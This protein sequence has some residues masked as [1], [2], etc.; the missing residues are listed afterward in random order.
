MV[1]K[2]SSILVAQ[3]KEDA[4]PVLREAFAEEKVK[5]VV[6]RD[7]GKVLGALEEGPAHVVIVDSS[8]EPEALELL[9]AVQERWPGMPLVLLMD[10]LSA[11]SMATAISLGA[12][13]L[14]V[15]PIGPKQL[16][17][18]VRKALTATRLS[19]AGPPPAAHRRGHHFWS[20]RDDAVVAGAPRRTR[21]IFTG[22]GR[23]SFPVGRWW[24]CVAAMARSSS[25]SPAT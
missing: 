15:R 12:D 10:E 6:H 20:V 22:S 3:L 18:S 24:C 8:G 14:L 1:D 9:R 17:F 21:S 19:A 2:L 16:L 5:L 13:D 7:A 25:G 23:R 11:S 4:D